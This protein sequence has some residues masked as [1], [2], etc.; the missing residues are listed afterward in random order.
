MRRNA[1]SIARN[2]SQRRIMRWGSVLSNGTRRALIDREWRKQMKTKTN[3]KAGSVSFSYGGVVW[4]Y[5]P[6]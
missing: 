4:T 5:K 1:M 2:V 3:V 6:Q